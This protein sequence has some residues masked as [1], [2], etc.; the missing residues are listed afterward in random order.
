[1]T[2]VAPQCHHT[3]VIDLECNV[4]G[5]RLIDAVNKIAGRPNWKPYITA[6]RIDGTQRYHIGQ[7]SSSTCD[8]VII[9]PISELFS[10]GFVRSD[11][12]YRL[13][14][15][16]NAATAYGKLMSPDKITAAVNG[17]ADRLKSYMTHLDD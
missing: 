6:N 14:R 3:V 12:E 4:T 9:V 11:D 2:L 1:M 15:V 8:L 17:Y 5:Q 16:R 7:I 10:D 13:L